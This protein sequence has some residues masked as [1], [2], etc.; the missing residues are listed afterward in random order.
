MRSRTIL[1]V[2]DEREIVDMIE[3]V[4][5]QAGYDILA[6][7]SPEQAAALCSE[8]E[9]SV[10]LVVSDYTMPGQN[11]MELAKTLRSMRPALEFIFISASPDAGA[12]LSAEGFLCLRKPFSLGELLGNIRQRL[13]ADEARFAGGPAALEGG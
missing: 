3:I 12:K 7:H 6:A 4:L 8:A 13:E 9:R 2:D 5:R 10:D 11:G 1:V